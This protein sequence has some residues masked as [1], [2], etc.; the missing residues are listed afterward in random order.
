MTMKIFF[1]HFKKHH[2]YCLPL[3]RVAMLDQCLP[4]KEQ[5]YNDEKSDGEAG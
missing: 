3:D 2:F 4:S 5:V 1:H